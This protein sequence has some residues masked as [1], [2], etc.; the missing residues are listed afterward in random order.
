MNHAIHEPWA[1]FLCLAKEIEGLGE[2][3]QEKV[4]AS[5]VETCEEDV[6]NIFYL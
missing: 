5:A 4:V 6:L 1:C 2:A 3:L